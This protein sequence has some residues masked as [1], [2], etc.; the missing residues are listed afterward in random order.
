MK[1]IA[2]FVTLFVLSTIGHAQID[3]SQFG[4]ET[5]D[6]AAIMHPIGEDGFIVVHDDSYVLFNNSLKRTVKVPLD[7]G[8]GTKFVSMYDWIDG[9]VVAI[10]RTYDK[11]VDEYSYT[12]IFIDAGGTMVNTENL[13]SLSEARREGNLARSIT[14]PDGNLHAHFIFALDKSNYLKELII[15][16]L[17]NEGSVVE[18][19]SFMPQFS[20][21]S[22]SFAKAVLAN[23]GTLYFA[24]TS[25]QQSKKKKGNT[26][27]CINLLRVNENG[28]T[29]FEFDEFEFGYIAS[30]SM[31]QMD[32]GNLFIGGFYSEEP[33]EN[34]PGRFVLV[35][36]P[37]QENFS[38]MN[39][40][41]LS[42]YEKTTPFDINV[43]DIRE[44]ESTVLMIGEEKRL[45]QRQT[46]D[47]IY[48]EWQTKDIVVSPFEK[49]G[50]IMPE[51]HIIKHLKSAGWQL[52]V[53]S[54]VI[55][56]GNTLGVIS[57]GS[58]KNQLAGKG[59]KLVNVGGTHAKTGTIV[60]LV[61]EE[62]TITEKK[63]EAPNAEKRAFIHVLYA[64]DNQAI[65][66][67]AK[68]KAGILGAMSLAGYDFKLRRVA[69]EQ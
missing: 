52:F 46:K 49:D 18:T 5:I 33:K 6:Y 4:A 23:D 44:M 35:F 7:F 56:V 31:I 61:S 28:E 17:N 65:L 22:F 26:N 11:S 16:I 38:G 12:K 51:T 58:H 48:Y 50:G 54:D 10:F 29:F 34:Q 66:L 45:I 55:K 68:P 3:F 21:E 19:R 59:E 41:R 40:R 42:K 64:D 9:G 62:G 39:A 37:Q 13:A 57:N 27:E 36:D 60:Y 15:L 32:N 30:M 14:S 53:N 1:K 8:K 20:N 25:K 2:L 67:Y 69:Y 47:G 63:L 24:F 43:L